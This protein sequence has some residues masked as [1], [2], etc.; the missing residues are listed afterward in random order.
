MEGAQSGAM[1]PQYDL[2]SKLLLG[3]AGAG[4]AAMSQDLLLVPDGEAI[5]SEGRSSRQTPVP[6]DPACNDS[7]S[8]PGV[9]A[10]G[11]SQLE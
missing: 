1:I 2:A 11:A 3:L 9:R 4:V 6:V 5:R 7:S 10:D 8:S